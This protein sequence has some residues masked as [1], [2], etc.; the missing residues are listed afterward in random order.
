MHHSI[1][2]EKEC[3]VWCVHSFISVLL[4]LNETLAI[5]SKTFIGFLGFVLFLNGA[6]DKLFWFRLSEFLSMVDFN[7]HYWACRLHRKQNSCKISAPNVL[8]FLW[9]RVQ[10]SQKIAFFFG[11]LSPIKTII[12]FAVYKLQLSYGAYLKANEMLTFSQNN[13]GF[14][15]TW[16][17]LWS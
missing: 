3:P 1:N 8:H 2:V 9:R 4:L 10:N 17:N 7:E 11:I 13:F 16:R 14:T 6:Q 15:I 5:L 12:T